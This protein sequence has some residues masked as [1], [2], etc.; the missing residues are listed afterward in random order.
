[1]KSTIQPRIYPV[2]I[3]NIIGIITFRNT[4]ALRAKLIN[5]MPLI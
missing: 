4:E 1:M 5:L 2:E 3:V